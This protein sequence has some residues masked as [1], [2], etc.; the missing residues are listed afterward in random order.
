MGH[1]VGFTFLSPDAKGRDGDLSDQLAWLPVGSNGSDI[2]GC[3]AFA[4]KMGPVDLTD[5]MAQ[6]PLVNKVNM[7]KSQIRLD[8]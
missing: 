3:L 5:P 7:V 8:S 1:T 4:R 6:L 2:S